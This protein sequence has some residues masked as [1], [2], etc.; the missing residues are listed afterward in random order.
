MSVI[1]KKITLFIASL[2]SGGAE[3]QMTFLANFLSEKGCDV[4]LVTY[5]DV[6]DCYSVSVKVSRIHLSPNKAVWKK[7]L[8]VFCY[9]Q[10]TKSDCVISFGTR[11]NCFTLFSLLFRPSV[12]CIASERCAFWGKKK[13]HQLMNYYILYRRAAVIVTNSHAQRKDIMAAYPRYKD[14]LITI[15]NYTDTS[16]YKVLPSP[17]N[18]PIQIGIFCRYMPQKN[19][20][21]FAKAVKIL[22]EKSKIPFHITWY[23]NKKL[24]NKA[25]TYYEHFCSL[26]KEYGIEDVL[27]LNDH[28]SKVSELL[29][30]FDALSLPSLIEG[31]SNSISEYICCGK[32][33]LCSD[34][35]DNSLMVEDGVNGFLFDPHQAEHIADAYLRFFCLPQEKRAQ[36]GINSRKK[37]EELFDKDRFVDSY[38][39]LLQ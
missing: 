9:Y 34:V 16:I 17:N 4:E 39:R 2:S 18:A 19:Y 3:H 23:G 29:P 13:W 15:T 21:A 28:T 1:E 22:K 20:V 6:E 26:V 27:T 35:A 24:G 31:F 14:K 7:L 8:S 25:N 37:A 10:K 32:P 11:D 5:S 38:I 12:K 30:T 33:V 36:M